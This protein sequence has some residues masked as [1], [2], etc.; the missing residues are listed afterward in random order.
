MT[1]RSAREPRPLQIALNATAAVSGGG[2]TYWVNMLPA[3]VELG[4]PHA[5]HLFLASSQSRLDGAIPAGIEIV[6]VGFPRPR[7]LSRL[8][9]EQVTLP[10]QLRAR[11][12][13]VLLAAAD[14]APL[15]SPCPVVMAI[16][17]ANPHWGPAGSTWQERGRERLLKALTRVSAHRASRVFFVSED[18]RRRIAPALGIPMSRTAVAYHGIGGRFLDGPDS[19]EGPASPDSGASASLPPDV[20]AS[21]YVLAVSA[22]R[23]HK[24]FEALLRAF[25]A[26]APRQARLRL[27]IAGAIIDPPYHAR[28]EGL[29]SSLGIRARVQFLGEVPYGELPGLYRGSRL[30]VFP[31]LAE[32]FGHPLLESMASGVPVI[33]TDLDVTREVCGGAAEFYAA[34]DWR[35]LAATMDRLLDDEPRRAR[36]V[37]AGRGRAREFSW[38]RCARRTLDLLEGAALER[39]GYPSEATD[40]PTK[41][42]STE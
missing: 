5:F 25:A 27:V 35:G 21:R 9:W 10:R 11:R 15:Y 16:R 12:I 29:A 23:V 41:D 31:T 14:V 30:F 2:V 28:L 26:L 24:D 36:L 8:L 20:S 40:E 13:D 6:R 39:R 17:N 37:E 32:T 18:S 22:V 38:Q 19:G 3:F 42:S 1:G 34:G 4:S 33:T 7:G